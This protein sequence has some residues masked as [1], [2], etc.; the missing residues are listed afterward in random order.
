MKKPVKKMSAAL[1]VLGLYTHAMRPTA[2]MKDEEQSSVVA[3]ETCVVSDA[4]QE[5]MVATPELEKEE[6]EAARYHHHTS[7]SLGNII[8]ELFK[9]IWHGIV[10]FFVA[11]KNAIASILNR[12]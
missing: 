8:A 10:S 12:R 9:G 2:Q 4:E 6:N 5:P 3:K 1:V 7:A 11:I